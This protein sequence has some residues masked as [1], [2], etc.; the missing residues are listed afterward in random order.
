M[1][2]LKIFF[3]VNID[4]VDPIKTKHLYIEIYFIQKREGYL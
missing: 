3:M 2:P 1:N 4:R